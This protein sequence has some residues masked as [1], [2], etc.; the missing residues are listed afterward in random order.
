LAAFQQNLFVN[1]INYQKLKE[2]II[3][4][5]IRKVI[6]INSVLT[7]NQYFSFYVFLTLIKKNF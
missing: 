6:G 7:T 2:L 1:S 4:L 3:L 5:K